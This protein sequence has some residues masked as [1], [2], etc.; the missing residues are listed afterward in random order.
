MDGV[1]IDSHPVH[2]RAWRQFLASVGKQVSDAQLEFILEGRR[3]EEI[4]RYFLGELPAETMAAYGRSKDQIFRES[5]DDVQLIPGVLDFLHA[6]R[7]ADMRIALATSGSA[8]RTRE[9]LHRLKLNE[10]FSAV[11]TSDDV[12]S[13]K[14]DPAVYVLASERMQLLPAEVIV[15]EDAACGLQAAKSAGMRCIAVATNG[16]VEALRA[17]GAD[18]VI[19]DFADFSL[20]ALQDVWS[21]S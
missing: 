13:G 21:K 11:V 19:P 17:A 8:Y 20:A 15:M 14:P 12:H 10:L 1:L 7:R 18:F 5:F 9:T 4:L 3:R 16:R 6:L 2:R